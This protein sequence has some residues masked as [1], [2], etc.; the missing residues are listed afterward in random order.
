MKAQVNFDSLG[1]GGTKFITGSITGTTTSTFMDCG[2]TP[3]HVVIIWFHT[4]DTYS[5]AVQENI[6]GTAYCSINGYRNYP[7]AATTI[8]TTGGFNYS[9]PGLD[10]DNGHSYFMAWE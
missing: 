6:E 5:P 3:T 7:N 4:S 8:L 2:F 10:W 1:G 9:I